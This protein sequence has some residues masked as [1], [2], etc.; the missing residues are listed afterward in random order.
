MKQSHPDQQVPRRVLNDLVMQ[1]LVTNGHEEAAEHFSRESGTDPPVDL[2][3]VDGRMRV[4]SAVMGGQSSQ[5]MALL[6]GAFPLLLEGRPAL[7]FALK[8]QHVIELIERGDADAA[9]DYATDELA[10]L[11]RD[12]EGLLA[13]LEQ[14]LMRL[15]LGADAHVALIGPPLTELR[16]ALVKQLNVAMLDHQY[17]AA[18]AAAHKVQQQQPPPPLPR[19]DFLQLLAHSQRTLRAMHCAEFSYVT[20]LTVEE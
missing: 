18:A 6:N 5:A 3:S 13:Q 20:G 4:L 10:P 16:R 9:L 7:V 2:R 1:Y 19:Y 17:A 11:A 8:R 12:D 14:A 15:A